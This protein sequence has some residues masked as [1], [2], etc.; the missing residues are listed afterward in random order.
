[1]LSFIYRL[2]LKIFYTLEKSN[3]IRYVQLGKNAHL[4][5]GA[6]ISNSVKDKT[7]IKIGDDSIIRAHLIVEDDGKII[8]GSN[9][10]IGDNSKLY[11]LASIRIGDR[12]LIAHNVNIYDNNSHPIQPID[13]YEQSKNQLQSLPTNNSHVVKSEIIIEDDVWIGMN[14]II[15]KGVTIGKASI[16]GAGS[17]VTKSIPAYT[18]VGGPQAEIIKKI[19][20]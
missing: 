18:I 2:L 17:I 3:N 15:L 5:P 4:K 6:K 20:P 19:N 11:S 1:M 7:K 16:V 9:S 14:S 12:V 10:Y 8:V 13:R